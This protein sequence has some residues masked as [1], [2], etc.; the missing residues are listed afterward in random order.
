MSK[1]CK[2]VPRVALLAAVLAAVAA[3]DSR[4]DARDDVLSAYRATYAGGKLRIRSEIDA[5]GRKM[6]QTVEI[7]LPDRYH[8]KS[9][10]MEAIV[11]PSGSFMRPGGQ[12]MRSPIDMGKMIQQFTEE[13]RKRSQDTISN[14]QDLGAES[15]DGHAAH[16]YSYDADGEAMGVKS[17]AHIKVWIDSAEQRILQMVVDGEAMGRKSTTTQHYEYDPSITI[18]APM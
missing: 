8:I 1:F 16:A 12:W 18:T 5:G 15:V 14:V 4:A 13:G 7:Q 10:Q 11:L 9:D 17:K 3:G 6:S 2:P